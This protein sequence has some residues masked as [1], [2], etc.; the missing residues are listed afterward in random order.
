MLKPVHTLADPDVAAPAEHEGVTR[1]DYER[2]ATLTGPLTEP[3]SGVPQVAYRRPPRASP[4]R[5]IVGA[6]AVLTIQTTFLVWLLLPSHFPILD[7]SPLLAAA[8]LVM[9]LSM[10]LIELFRLVNVGSLCLASALARDPV[11][12][13]PEAGTRVAFITTIVPSSEP[14]AVVRPTL[15]AAR[16]VR[17]QGV[18]DVWLLDEGDDP[19]VRAMCIELGVHHFTRHGVERWNLS[20]GPF[21]ART[22]HGNYNAWVDGH[23]DDYDFFV[24]VDPDHV[25]LPSFCERLLGY[26]R[27]PDVA[28]AVGPQ[29]YGNFDNFVTKCAESQQF[30]FHGLIQ[31][32]GNY[33]RS[34]MLVGTNNAVRIS[35]LREIGG[36]QDSITEDLATSLSCHSTRNSR[37]GRRWR[38]VYTPDV[39]AVGEGPANFTDF[40]SQQ[41]RWSRGTF[42]TLRGH[43][44][45]CQRRLSWGARLHYSLITSYYPSAALGWI[46]GTVNCSLY[47]LFGTSGIRVQAQ[48]WIAMY[49]DLAVVQFCLYASNRK[50]NVSPHESE[51]SSGAA[52]VFISVLAAPVYV[53]ALLGSLARRGSGFVVTPKGAARSA[54]GL[55][56]FRW[57]LAWGAVLAIAL[58]ASAWMDHPQSSMRL[59]SLTLVCV[60]LTPATIAFAR[61]AR[62]SARARREAP[63]DAA[64][65]ELAGPM[66]R[67]ETGRLVIE[68][69]VG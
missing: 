15:E 49:L 61:R 30:V 11:P 51:G 24:S 31:R 64:G 33:F 10:Y 38:S 34:P 42:E 4:L 17:H 29:V 22:K 37:T 25:P 39:L 2:F 7:S 63:A 60:C 55:R 48:A 58:G 3:G 45:R 21:K 41:H 14:I 36:L 40:F 8:S 9:L 50:H 47:L 59:W 68:S 28:F 18:I 26:F 5:Q 27:D 19:D 12:M 13:V 20:H 16:R 43:Y 57:H 56:T 67:G 46:L 53:R 32:M 35:A 65:S 44:W 6:G 52:G 66:T 1:F 69:E 62:S 54:D 23:G